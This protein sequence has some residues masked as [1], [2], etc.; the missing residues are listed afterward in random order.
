MKFNLSRLFHHKQTEFGVPRGLA[1]A[2][3]AVVAATYL[4]SLIFSLAVSGGYLFQ[5]QT[6]QD[7]YYLFFILS[8]NLPPIAYFVVAYLLHPPKA[9]WQ[10]RSFVAMV[11]A[12]IGVLAAQ[13]FTTASQYGGLLLGQEVGESQAVTLLAI[14]T[15]LPLL[16]FVAVLLWLRQSN[17]W[18]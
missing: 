14:I 10:Q 3:M 17:R 2:F 1:L 15:A 9:G 18:R 8:S 7:N 4:Y 11:L 6:L 16:G 13:L 5:P 12:V